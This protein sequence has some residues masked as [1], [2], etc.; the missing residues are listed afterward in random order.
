MANV[1]SLDGIRQGD[2][3]E[4]FSECMSTQN[5]PKNGVIENYIKLFGKVVDL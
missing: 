5:P 2:L 1:V 4:Y 3:K